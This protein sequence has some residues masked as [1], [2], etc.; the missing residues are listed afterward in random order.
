MLTARLLSKSTLILA[1]IALLSLALLHGRNARADSLAGGPGGTVFVADDMAFSLPAPALD[2]ESRDAF[3]AGRRL[4][5]VSWRPR[6]FSEATADQVGLGP[7]FNRRSC[8]GCHV[9][10]GRGQPAAAGDTGPARGMILRLSAQT[11]GA[12][13]PHH[14]LGAQLQDQAVPGVAREGR[15]EVTYRERPGQFADGSGFSLRIPTYAISGSTTDHPIWLSPRVPPAVFGGGLL[16]AVAPATL[17]ALADPTDADGDGISGR[18]ALI[19][20]PA[21]RAIGRFGWK[22]TRASLRDQVIEAAAED[23]GLASV[24]RPLAGCTP[25]QAA[26]IAAC[27]QD[28]ELDDR[29][30]EQL[31]TY[32]RGLAAP[33]RRNQDDPQ[34]QRGEILF[35]KAGCDRCHRSSLATGDN[36]PLPG[37]GNQTIHPYTDLLLH[38]MGDGLA[39]LAPDGAANGREWRTAPLWGIGLVPTVNGHRFFLHDGRARSVMEAVLWHAGEAAAARQSVL[40]WPARDRAALVAFLSSL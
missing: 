31:V 5:R 8:A 35:Q 2:A 17:E 28:E 36:P 29:A 25:A 34:V 33:A 18:I 39:D 38:D 24:D 40:A 19:D 26:T 32:L 21:G 30:I 11:A 7:M 6:A 3:A 9:K 16:E 13:E 37:F 20:Q 15:I 1:A 22:A 10:N 14:V 12:P 27:L 23:L 4:F